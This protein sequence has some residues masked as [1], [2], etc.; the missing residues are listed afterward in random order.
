MTLTIPHH[1]HRSVKTLLQLINSR[2]VDC[3]E[4]SRKAGFHSSAIYAWRRRASPSVDNLE[5]TLNVLGYGIIALPL[6]EIA[7][8]TEPK[9]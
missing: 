6:E 3:Q 2:G 7:R 4:V 8:L 1:L 9:S 5:A